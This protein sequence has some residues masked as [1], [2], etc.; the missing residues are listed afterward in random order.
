MAG[1]GI[2]KHRIGDVMQKQRRTLQVEWTASGLNMYVLRKIA[3]EELLSEL[4]DVFGYT[5]TDAEAENIALCSAAEILKDKHGNLYLHADDAI[6]TLSETLNVYMVRDIDRGNRGITKVFLP[7]IEIDDEREGEGSRNDPLDGF[8]S[9]LD[10]QVIMVWM[11]DECGSEALVTPAFYEHNGT[12]V[13]P[14]CGDDMQYI[15]T[16]ISA[17]VIKKGAGN[18]LPV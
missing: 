17:D 1:Y 13:C 8:I 3:E 10:S 12:P 16:Y 14:E 7:K 9:I 4:R 18:D 11:H 6:R 2:K 15:R 5:M